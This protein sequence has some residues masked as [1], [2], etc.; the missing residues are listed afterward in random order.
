MIPE[1][2][3]INKPDTERQ[4]SPHLPVES[5]KQFQKEG[6]KW[7]LSRATVGRPLVKRTV[8]SRKHKGN[9]KIY[10]TT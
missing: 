10:C 3:L 2:V 7:R 5:E 4:L 8:S 6:I 9:A 1:V